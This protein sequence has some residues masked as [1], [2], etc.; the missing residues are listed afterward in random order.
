MKPDNR[1]FT[2]ARESGRGYHDLGG[3]DAGPV[4]H[5]VTEANRWEKLAIVVGNALGPKGAKILR[6]DEIRR[7]R[8]EMGVVLYNELGYFEKNVEA[9]RRLL[10]DKGVIEPQE[11]ESRMAQIG[12]RIGEDGR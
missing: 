9:I 5:E 11:L 7:V 4:E 3:L 6:T 12:K 2:S 8:E 1:T 10:V